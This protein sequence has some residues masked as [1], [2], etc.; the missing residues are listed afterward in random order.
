VILCRNEMMWQGPFSMSTNSVG[1]VVAIPKYVEDA[2]SE[3]VAIGIFAHEFGHIK[4]GRSWDEAMADDL[5]AQWVG[6][7]TVIKALLA[8]SA[9][10]RE[11]HP[12]FWEIYKIEKRITDRILRL[13]MQP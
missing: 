7:E 1:S 2:V 13:E 9:L 4:S 10:V 12:Q 11:Q 8:I 3:K 6:P 5:A